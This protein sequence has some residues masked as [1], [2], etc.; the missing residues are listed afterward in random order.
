MNEIWSVLRTLWRA[1]GAYKIEIQFDPQTDL[2]EF[3]DRLGCNYAAN[4]QFSITEDGS[5]SANHSWKFEHTDFNNKP[6][7]NWDDCSFEYS[8]S[9]NGVW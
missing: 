3:G 4:H 8:W 6:D 1:L 5:W 2:M 7:P 9:G